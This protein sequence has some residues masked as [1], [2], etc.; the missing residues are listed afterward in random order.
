MKCACLVSYKRSIFSPF[1]FLLSAS[2]LILFN[3]D[4]PVH[5][6]VHSRC[7]SSFVSDPNIKVAALR[8]RVLRPLASSSS[9]TAATIAS[10]SHRLDAFLSRAMESPL[11]PMRGGA[12]IAPR[13]VV[14][15]P[16]PV[17][18]CAITCIYALIFTMHLSGVIRVS[19]PSLSCLLV[20]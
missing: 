3:L 18:G 16:V 17:S 4:A 19:S 20:Y 2:Q 14:A 8:T 6:P 10:L 9:A 13:G 15:C 12:G 1:D 7:L 11:P 5:V